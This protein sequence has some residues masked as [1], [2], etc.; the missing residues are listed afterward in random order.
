[1]I[2]GRNYYPVY[3]LLIVALITGTVTAQTNSYR[4]TNL[5]SDVPGAANFRS[6]TLLNPWGVAFLPGQPFVIADNGS[7]RTSTHNADGSFAG[8]GFLV[9]TTE[10]DGPDNPTAIVADPTRSFFIAGGIPQFIVATDTGRISGWGPDDRGDIPVQAAVVVDHS[11]RGDSYTGLAILQPPCC[12][13]FLAAAD[14]HGGVIRSYNRSLAGLSPPGSFI[15]PNLPAGYAPFGIHVIG[16]HVFITYALQDASGRSPAVG[17]GNGLVSIFDLEGNFMRR[18]ATG[19]TLNAPWGVTQA[20]ANFGAFSNDILVGNFGDGSISAFDPATASFVGQLADGN[21]NIIRNSA[22]WELTFRADGFGDPNTLYF[23]AGIGNEQHGL[24][25]A[26]TTSDRVASDFS[27]TAT[28]S[29]ATIAS[30]Q[31]AN[32]LVTLTPTGG[33]SANVALACTAPAGVS[34]NIAPGS[35]NVTTGPVTA[36]VTAAL[37]PIAAKDGGST[38]ALF[39]GFGILGVVLAPTSR[40]QCRVGRWVAGL[41]GLAL[42]ASMLGC[43]SSSAIK[44]T[45]VTASVVITASAGTTQ[46]STT[47]NLN[48][49]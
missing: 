15:D 32:F 19:G 9:A 35:V 34:C 18:F 21:G 31:S 23:T 27:L 4:Q 11:A 20:S 40:L 41:L 1:M 16:E 44:T 26:L 5:A 36:T 24:F 8:P 17:A 46:H 29:N 49:R 10:G 37:S 30:G 28:P 3:C 48:V 47:V 22:L 43:G 25:G 13:I 39:A 14:F 42:L 38:L 2:P 12:T 45:D 6:P 33:F 7:G